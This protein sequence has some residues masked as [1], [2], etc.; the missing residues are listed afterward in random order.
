MLRFKPN[1][2]LHAWSVPRIVIRPNPIL[3]R[4]VNTSVPLLF[5]SPEVLTSIEVALVLP[6][7]LDLE[8]FLAWAPSTVDLSRSYHRREVAD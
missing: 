7:D 8:E 4:H 6:A 3:Q 2:F 1:E 5:N